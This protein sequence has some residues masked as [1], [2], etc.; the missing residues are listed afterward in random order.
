MMIKAA[1]E[2]VAVVDKDGTI[3]IGRQALRDAMYATKDY[4]G[5]TGTLTCSPTGDCANPVIGVYE[6]HKGQYPPELIWQP[7]E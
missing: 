1:I 3:H 4:K 5:L 6:Y 7:S 2:K